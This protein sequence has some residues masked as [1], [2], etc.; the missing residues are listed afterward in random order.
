MCKNSEHVEKYQIKSNQHKTFTK[1]AD[2]KQV[3]VILSLMLIIKISS[4]ILL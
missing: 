4:H 2:L 3:F 1:I